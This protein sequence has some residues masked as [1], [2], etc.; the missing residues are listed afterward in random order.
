MTLAIQSVYR[1]L[2]MLG[3]PP[4]EIKTNYAPD[5]DT[6]AGIAVPSLE[7]AL[8]LKN[9]KVKSLIDAKWN[10]QHLAEGDI[11]AFDRVF[12]SVMEAEVSASYTHVEQS[13]TNTSKAE[14]LLYEA[15]VRKGAH[16][17]SKMS[18]NKVF[19]ND[20]GSVIAKPDFTWDAEKI[21]VE[22]DGSWHHGERDD[23]ALMK[24]IQKGDSKTLVARKKSKH[25]KDADKRRKI[26]ELGWNVIIVTDEG[27]YGPGAAAKA[28][29]VADSIVR[30]LRNKQ[31]EMNFGAIDDTDKQS[32]KDLFDSEAPE[33]ESDTDTDDAYSYDPPNKDEEDD[34]A[35]TYEPTNGDTTEPDSDDE[36]EAE[37]ST[38][39]SEDELQDGDE[40][41]DD[42][43]LM[44]IFNKLQENDENS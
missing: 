18:R 16:T 32:I 24:A 21:I 26:A 23:A 31:A 34:S 2:M 44:D 37:P 35:S 22:F 39:E 10:V 40:F 41:S 38:D 42:D 33:D 8:A 7:F 12:K 4:S 30:A 1:M 28:D 17:I 25:A 6:R 11:A 36:S 9:D 3:V 14:D 27:F 5:P 20:D 43:D 29:E 19:R 13:T 15:L